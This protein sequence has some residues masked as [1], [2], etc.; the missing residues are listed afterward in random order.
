[1]ADLNDLLREQGIEYPSLLSTK[2]KTT[3]HAWTSG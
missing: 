2:Q 1:M 3:E